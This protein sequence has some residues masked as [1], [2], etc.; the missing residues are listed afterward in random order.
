MAGCLRTRQAGACH[1]DQ[2]PLLTGRLLEAVFRQPWRNNRLI[3]RKDY[4]DKAVAKNLDCLDMLLYSIL[5]C[6]IL[7]QDQYLVILTVVTI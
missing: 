7:D 2:V 4:P 5:K 6:V 3:Q 1:P